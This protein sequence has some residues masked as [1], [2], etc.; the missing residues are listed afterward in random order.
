MAS[1]PL[2]FL[3]SLRWTRSVPR[4]V[5]QKTI[6]CS[7]C[8]RSNKPKQQIEFT[9]FFDREVV[10]F[11]RIDTF[12]LWREVHDLGVDHVALCES[13]DAGGNCSAQQKRLSL[14]GAA[15]QDFFDVGTKSDV[16]HAVGF[17]EHN[18]QQF[19]KNQRTAGQVVQYSS[20]CANDY[21][22]ATL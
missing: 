5:R 4:L 2:S 1:T 21:V 6:A 11:N 13:F 10:L 18:G 3:E 8:S 9:L 16:E 20:R 22:A 15:T 17:V 19:F 7:G 12:G 14:L